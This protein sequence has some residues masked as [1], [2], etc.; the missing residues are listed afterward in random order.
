MSPRHLWERI[1]D[2]LWFLPAALTVA[3]AVLAPAMVL[4]DQRWLSPAQM[5]ELWW[6]FG[7][8]PEGARGVLV[9]IAGSLI[10]VTGVVFSITIVALQL[11]SSQFTPR[12]LQNFTGDRGNQVVLG[13]FV[14]TFT[15][16][17]LVLRTVRSAV[18][19]GAAGFVPAAGVTLAVLLALVSIGC[20]IF[21]IHHVSTWI[22]ASTIVDRV[23]NETMHVIEKRFPAPEEAEGDG[24]AGDEDPPPPPGAPA[25]VASRRTGYLQLVELDDLVELAD[26][27]GL[28]IRVDA[29]VGDFVLAG[30]PL[31]SVWPDAG[32]ASAEDESAGDAPAEDGTADAVRSAFNFGHRRTLPHD[33]ELGFLQLSDIAVKAL[34]PGIN[35]PTT[36][37]MALDRAAELVVALAGRRRIESLPGEDGTLRL[38]VPSLHFERVVDVA[39]SQARRYGGRDAALLVHLIGLV[40]QIARQVGPAQRRPLADLLHAIDEQARLDIEHTGD[41]ATVRHALDE[42][43]RVV[44]RLDER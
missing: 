20:L 40:H 39:F 38:L 15:Y 7:G 19:D 37:M 10:T 43:R 44:D 32:E 25:T 36:A 33:A 29:A 1:R 28:V 17:L 26:R 3:A 35:D 30:Q 8:S 4:V 42:A 11:A 12:V 31:A 22:E 27:E 24:G 41:L 34:S 5:G 13:V 14:G 21:Y 23:A 16:T 9:A 6:V 2:S 18:D